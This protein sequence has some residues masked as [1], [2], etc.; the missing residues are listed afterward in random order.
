DCRI[1]RKNWFYSENDAHTL[2]SLDE[3]MGLYYYSVGRGA[4]LLINI[5][6]DRRGLLPDADA[7]RFIE[8]GKAVKE[9]FS[10]PICANITQNGNKY[11]VELPDE[12]VVNH[13][14]LEEE[15][16]EGDKITAFAVY[17]YPTHFGKPIL[18]YRGETIGHKHI[19]NF[20]AVC[21]QKIEVV[22]EKESAAHTMS[23]INVYYV[24]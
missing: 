19:C 17:A 23:K 1:R 3:L 13:V 20:P 15:L 18:V 7:A 24:K 9:R 11:T 5:G 21:T 22:V 4:N 10:N 8:F 14:V 16:S 6:P 2:K 12:T